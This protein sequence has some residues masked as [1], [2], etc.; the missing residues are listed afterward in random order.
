MKNLIV[1]ILFLMLPVLSIG[2]AGYEIG[3]PFVRNYTTTDYQAHAQNFAIA[4]DQQGIMYFGNFAGVLQYDGETWRLIP[5][6]NTTKVSA[7]AIDSAGKVYVGA[8]GEI[9]FLEPDKTG[10]LKFTSLLKD[11]KAKYPPF[12]D[13]LHVFIVGNKVH[14]IAGN[15]IF[16][17]ENGE[18]TIWTAPR[19]IQNAFLVR[20]IIFLQVKETGLV[21]WR[22]KKLEAHDQGAIFSGARV[23]SAM[24]PYHGTKTLIATSSQGLFLMEEGTIRPFNAKA[25]DLL[26]KNPVTSGVALSDGTIALGTSRMGI[27]VMS[28]DG[29]IRQIIDKGASL[30]NSFVQ[31]LYINNDNTLW[32]ALNNGISMIEI[33]SPLTYFDEK[34][35]LMGGVNQV[36]RFQNTCY[37]ATYQGL[38]YYDEASLGF[39]PVK[40]IISACWRIVSFNNDL[41]AAT[42][43]GIFAVRNKKATLIR[44]GFT[45]S[46]ITSTKEPSSLYLGETSGFYK[47]TRKGGDWVVQKF[48]G[49]DEEI[50]DLK[51]D[52]S[53][54]IW[55]L[56]LSKGL[57]RYIPGEAALSFFNEKNGLPGNQGLTINPLN[58]TI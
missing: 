5:T 3:F 9:G 57:F 37:V 32:A 26:T 46:L 25:N 17:L 11:F 40:E 47:M 24:L 1:A 21:T 10:T 41:F 28:D 44:D 45:L 23:I 16:T 55:G 19:E 8:R 51:T 2:Q 13:I 42:S 7:L 48:A 33:P 34:S 50:D 38:Y 58:N 27:I 35:G 30:Q 39:L 4:G 53:G 43:Q 20:D 54:N 18:I 12:Y 6:E 22:D 36:M 14:F 15:L 52:I 29:N 49:V 31:T 56:S